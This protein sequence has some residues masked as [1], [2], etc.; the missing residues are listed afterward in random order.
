MSLSVCSVYFLP[1]QNVQ[2]SAGP[3]RLGA[4]MTERVSP[5]VIRHRPRLPPPISRRSKGTPVTIRSPSTAP[6]GRCE[7][8]PK[9][10]RGRGEDP[11]TA[12]HIRSWFGASVVPPAARMQICP[13]PPRKTEYSAPIV[14]RR[15]G[16]GKSRQH[17][18]KQV[19]VHCTAMYLCSVRMNE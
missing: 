16:G 17:T 9:T 5:H 2:G 10:R 1:L 7:R 8:T 12:D 18:T 11:I 14:R 19:W 3:S 4:K 6:G 15:R 13:E